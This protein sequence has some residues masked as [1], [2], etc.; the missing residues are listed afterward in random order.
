MTSVYATCS[1]CRGDCGAFG[2]IGWERCRA[3][4][5]LGR[6]WAAGAPGYGCEATLADATAGEIV[7]LGNGDQGRVLWHMPRRAKKIRPDTT[8]LGMIEP[9][10]EIESYIPIAYPSCVGV[11]SVDASRN[12]VDDNAHAHERGVDL[13]DPVQR[14]IAGRLM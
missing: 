13:S 1:S 2:S 8:F 4:D 3:C 9:F 7:T 10:T 5:G 11:S 6:M 14:T 12:N